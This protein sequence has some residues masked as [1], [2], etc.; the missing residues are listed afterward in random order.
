MNK[1]SREKQIQVLNCLVE[2][3][4]VRG[5]SRLTGV[6]KNTITK[7][8]LEAG[9]ACWAYHYQNVRDLASKRVQCDEI[10]AFVGAKEKNVPVEKKNEM[11]SFYTWTA[12]DADSKLIISYHVGD[13]SAVSAN[14]F[15]MDLASRLRRRIQLT[16]DGHHPYRE[17]VEL[18]FPQGVDYA[19]LI[20]QYGNVPNDVR[21]EK[22][23]SPAE[24]TGIKVEQIQG[25]PNPKHIS[26]SFVER[27]NLN[28]R[29]SNRRFTRLTNAFSKKV[30]N[31]EA[32]CALNFM[33]HNFVRI[34]QTLRMSP[35]MSAGILKHLWNMGDIV[36][37]LNK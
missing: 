19:M 7:L 33:Y 11:G 29:M 13:R 20:K 25:Q 16:T 30:A 22:R 1:L 3:V 15:M 32:A 18:A 28:I 27:Q 34:H 24:C 6:A 9:D 17:A 31:L 2:G 10:W 14:E 8:L 23:Y 26:T 36:D 12:I 35:A 4:S 21:A 37:L 5:T